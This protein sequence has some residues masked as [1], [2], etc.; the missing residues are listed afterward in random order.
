MRERGEAPEEG[1]GVDGGEAEANHRPRPTLLVTDSLSEQLPKTP[2][3]CGRLVADAYEKGDMLRCTERGKAMGAADGMLSLLWPQ[4]TECGPFSAIRVRLLGCT[5]AIGL[6]PEG[7]AV[8]I[9]KTR[10][11]A[12]GGLR[13]RARDRR[14]S[15]EPVV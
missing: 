4:L 7:L 13:V 12:E 8:L 2:N 10:S 1:D 6:R 5:D 9:S 15:C 14:G 11:A 3:N